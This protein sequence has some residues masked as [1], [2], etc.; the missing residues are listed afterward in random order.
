MKKPIDETF[1]T[2][3]EE[4]SPRLFDANGEILCVGDTVY[5]IGDPDDAMLSYYDGCEATVDSI[6]TLEIVKPRVKIIFDDGV[7]RTMDPK[8]LSL[9]KLDT[10]EQ[11]YADARKNCWEY[12][13]CGFFDDK[14]V[15]CN[16]C[17]IKI[18]GRTPREHYG[19]KEC[20]KAQTLDI[21]DR[22]RR[23]MERAMYGGEL[24]K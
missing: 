2:I 23:L 6:D 1:D 8:N 21:L 15:S 22:Y 4:V 14:E 18:D 13:Q 17:P 19:V 12:F 9:K 20:C 10:E 24:R 11:L 5:I 16:K 7:T 3:E